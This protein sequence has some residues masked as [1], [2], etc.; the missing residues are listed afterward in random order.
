MIRSR[1]PLTTSFLI[2]LFGGLF[3]TA[4]PAFAWGPEGHAIIA[5]IA[6]RYLNPEAAGE[7]RHLL[8]ATDL[9]SAANWPDRVEAALP[10]T[11]PWHYANIPSGANGY[12]ASRDC[13]Q[14][15][16]V[17]AKI[18]WFSHILADPQQS[19]EARLVALKF[20]IHLVGDIHQPFHD[21][22]DARGGNDIVVTLFGKQ[23][24]G[25][26]ACELH[27]VWDTALIRHTGMTRR[28]YADSLE[29]M[30]ANGKLD[31][32]SDDPSAWADESF[33]LAKEALVSP[34]AQIGQRYYLRERPVLDRQ[35]ALAGLRL[36]RLLNQDLDATDGPR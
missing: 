19:P 24:C 31:A 34:G 21:L 11:A 18:Q 8:G 4:S 3:L 28:Q 25:D 23:Q 26:R 12:L 32:G 35:L 33:Q 5:E 7:L 20:L 17:V 22:A 16:C 1:K 15:N 14:N 2:L 6:A 29:R 27:Y 36:A 13:P 30:I 10:E 9:S